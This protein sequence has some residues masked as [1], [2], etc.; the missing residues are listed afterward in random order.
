MF[1]RGSFFVRFV[2]FL[3]VIG[4]LVGGGA[5][6]YRAGFTQ[7]YVQ[8][9]A[10]GAA[11]TTQAAPGLPNQPVPYYPGFWPWWGYPH[12]GFFPFAGILGFFLFIFLFFGLMRLLFRPHYWGPMGAYPGTGT[13]GE[14]L[15]GHRG[16]SLAAQPV[17]ARETL[18]TSQRTLDR[19]ILSAVRHSPDGCCLPRLSGKLILCK[20]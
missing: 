7:G 5:L 9:A 17:R 3:L 15:L 14:H 11:G 1:G 16:I 12:F 13:D 10:T 4:I 18:K 19:T 6:L 8:G 20:S 2:V